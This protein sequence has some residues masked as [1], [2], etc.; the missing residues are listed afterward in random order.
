MYSVRFKVVLRK[1]DDPRRLE[2]STKFMSLIAC[3][4]ATEIPH[5][6]MYY[7]VV[8]PYPRV[9]LSKTYR[10]CPKPQ[11]VANPIN[12]LFFVYIHTYDKV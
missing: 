6:S 8:P 1:N 3:T 2:L 9:I 10:G 4:V 7:T 12:K 11:I 5:L